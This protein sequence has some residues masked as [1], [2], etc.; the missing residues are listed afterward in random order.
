MNFVEIP[1][2]TPGFF[3]KTRFKKFSTDFS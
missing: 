1:G 2:N 3:F